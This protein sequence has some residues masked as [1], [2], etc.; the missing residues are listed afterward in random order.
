M[1]TGKQAFAGETLTD[2]LAA[3]VRAD[4]EW[5]TLPTETPD[6]IDHL[7]R[8]CLTKDAKQ[9]LR[10]IGEARIEIE[11]CLAHPDARSA[12]TVAARRPAIKSWALWA[13]V[14][15]AIAF[16]ISLVLLWRSTRPDTRPVLPYDSSPP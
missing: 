8:R 12:A 14:V 3:V 9:R 5:D 13:S 2:T 7:L 15:L 11:E 16:V 10:D 1:L 4:P 6:V